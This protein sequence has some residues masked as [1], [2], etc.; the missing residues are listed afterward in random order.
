MSWGASEKRGLQSMRPPHQWGN[1]TPL[2]EARHGVPSGQE[3]V[4]APMTLQ[5]RGGWGAF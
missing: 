4:W 1:P 5:G 2:Q 3:A